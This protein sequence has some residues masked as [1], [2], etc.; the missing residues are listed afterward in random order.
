MERPEARTG[1]V[2]GDL[3]GW[4]LGNA[5]ALIGAGLTVL[6]AY[7]Y[8]GS[9]EVSLVPMGSYG[10]WSAIV[11]RCLVWYGLP[12]V[13]E[14]LGEVL[15]SADQSDSSELMDALWT[16]FKGE[17]FTAKQV[18]DH[19]RNKDSL[20]SVLDDVLHKDA[21]TAKGLGFALRKLRGRVVGGRTVDRRRTHEGYEW[22][23]SCRV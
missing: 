4:A 1:F 15:D 22:R 19:A 5:G 10:A 13:A 11:R 2:H 6:R 21:R 14:G 17:P 18:I 3:I 7:T 20:Q 12:D 8:A 9:P 16:A 23:I